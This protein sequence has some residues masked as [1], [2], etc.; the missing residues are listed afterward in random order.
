MPISAPLDNM[1][2]R[3]SR[4][5]GAIPRMMPVRR[6]HRPGEFRGRY[7]RRRHRLQAQAMGAGVIDATVAPT[8]TSTAFPQLAAERAVRSPTESPAPIARKREPPD[9]PCVRRQAPPLGRDLAGRVRAWPFPSRQQVRQP[10]GGWR[11]V[12]LVRQRHR[13]QVRPADRR[14]RGP[15]CRAD[16]HR[17][18][19]HP[20]APRSPTGPAPPL[21]DASTRASLTP[22]NLRNAGVMR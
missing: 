13:R 15:S 6:R 10:L 3:C 2:H 19:Q 21:D 8:T 18:T 22:P 20:S 9:F 4:A 7:R 5:D 14:R 11:P 17:P 12:A 16:R 1:L